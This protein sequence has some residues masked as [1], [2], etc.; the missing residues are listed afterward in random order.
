M[1]MKA[2][3]GLSMNGVGLRAGGE[4][5]AGVVSEEELAERFDVTIRST[6]PPRVRIGPKGLEAPLRDVVETA[7]SRGPASLPDRA[8]RGASTSWLHAHH[9]VPE[10]DFPRSWIG[11]ATAWRARAAA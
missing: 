3:P 10:N 7:G 4:P 11:C 1:S 2:T 8:R 6:E 5:S 9:I